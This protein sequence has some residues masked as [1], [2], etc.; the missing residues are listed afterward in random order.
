MAGVL[1]F[2]YTAIFIQNFHDRSQIKYIQTMIAYN[3]AMGQDMKDVAEAVG[4]AAV[5]GAGSPLECNLLAVATAE[6]LEKGKCR[7]ELER[8]C[9]FLQMLQTALKEYM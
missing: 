8:I 2:I 6:A 9:R 3:F 5:C 1:S 4:K 7:E